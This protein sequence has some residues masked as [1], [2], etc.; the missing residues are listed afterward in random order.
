VAGCLYTVFVNSLAG[1]SRS[2]SVIVAYVMSVT[3]LSYYRALDAVRGARE[4]ARPN[5]GFQQQL[6]TF[7]DEGVV[8]VG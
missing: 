6:L 8:K 2:S 4:C 3:D 1:V 7:E 5:F